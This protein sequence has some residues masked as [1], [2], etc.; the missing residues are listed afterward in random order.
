MI[1]LIK[2]IPDHRFHGDSDDLLKSLIR[3]WRRNMEDET[4]DA[5]ICKQL[6]DDAY[7]VLG[8]RCAIEYIK[9]YGE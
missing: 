2:P 1:E 9:K 4:A 6:I 5:E 3:I 7:K 8:Y